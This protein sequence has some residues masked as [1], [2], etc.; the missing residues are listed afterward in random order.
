MILQIYNIDNN[1]IFII[2]IMVRLIDFRA[3]L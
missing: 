3:L 2:D 1:R